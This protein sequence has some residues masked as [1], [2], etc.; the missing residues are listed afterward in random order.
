VELC[1]GAVAKDSSAAFEDV[2]GK[3]RHSSAPIGD[4]L[5]IALRRAVIAG[6][7]SVSR[8]RIK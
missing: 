4:T 8:R 2:G 1:G 7:F 3:R 5:T 6:R